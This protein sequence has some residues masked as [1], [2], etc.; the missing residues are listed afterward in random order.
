MNRPEQP[1]NRAYDGER[2]TGTGESVT[3]R[4]TVIMLAADVTVVRSLPRTAEALGIAVRP[5]G[6]VPRQLGLSRSNLAAL[7][8]DGAVGQTLLIPARDGATLIAVGV[9]ATPTTNELRDAAAAFARAASR[10]THLATNIVYGAAEPAT[11]AQAVVEGAVLARYRYEGAKT[12]SVG[13]PDLACAL[14][15]VQPQAWA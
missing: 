10:F 3:T 6:T 13:S 4:Q 1:V 5:T 12:A 9:G 14:A 2:R 7:G 8:F 15:R 11:A